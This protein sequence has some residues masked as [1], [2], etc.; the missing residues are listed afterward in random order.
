MLQTYQSMVQPERDNVIKVLWVHQLSVI[1]VYR[2]ERGKYK[3]WKDRRE[4][5]TVC[6]VRLAINIVQYLYEVIIISQVELLTV[7]TG[8]VRTVNMLSLN[9]TSS[10]ATR[11]RSSLAGSIK[12]MMSTKTHNPKNTVCITCY[13]AIIKCYKRHE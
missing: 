10:D 11:P 13:M 2:P 1:G 8:N 3:L 4:T 5:S 7:P 6:A 9:L 12:W